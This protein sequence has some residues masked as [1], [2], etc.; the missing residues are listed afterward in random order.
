VVLPISSKGAAA[1]GPIIPAEVGYDPEPEETM[2]GPV[3]ADLSGRT[4]L[5]TGGSAGIGKAVAQELALL[6]ARVVLACRSTERG[7]KARREI[8]SKAGPGE[9]EVME[10][11]LSRQGSIREFARTFAARHPA[12]DVLVNN[13]GVW[14][15]RREE[16]AEGIEMTW[17]TNVLGYFLLTELLLPALRRAAPAR[18]VNVASLLAGG[19]DPRDVEFKTRPYRGR[20]AYAQSKQANRMF[21]WAL[22]RRLAGTG[23]T[24]N[25]MHPGF[26]N[27]ELFQKAGGPL[28]V[29][30]SLWARLQAKRPEEGAD[31]AVWLAGSPEVEGRADAFWIDREERSCRFRDPVAEEELWALC[32]AMTRPV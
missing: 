9:V 25:A 20:A 8:L 21:T 18:V 24:A 3:R 7:E 11:D 12:L 5:V 19:L 32:E 15:Q 22:A 16:S 13:A 23:V 10:V 6:G 17:A 1:T 2:P 30:A 28:G 31:T 29:A 27:T 4:C 14:L 26:V